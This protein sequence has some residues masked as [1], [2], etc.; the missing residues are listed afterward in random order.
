MS[1]PGLPS[2]REAWEHH[3][4]QWIAYARTPGHDHCFW[5]YNL[6]RF[7]E[8][9]P[10]GRELTVDVGCGEGRVARALTG[11]GHRVVGLDSS[12]TLAACAAS[13]SDEPVLTTVADAAAL[14][15]PNGVADRAVAFMSLQD[16]H[17]LERA[18]GELG[19]V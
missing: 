5:A 6:P 4:E 19:R 9:L 17:D 10:P 1:D 16:V 2:P 8:I 18:V 12:P 7:L 3:A 14:P 11:L 15:L 13:H